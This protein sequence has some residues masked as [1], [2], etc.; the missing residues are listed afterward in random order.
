MAVIFNPDNVDSWLFKIYVKEK[1]MTMTKEELAKMLDRSQYPFKVTKAFKE[2]AKS[3]NLVIVYGAS[4]DLMEFRGAIDE[5]L[6]A[7]D[8]TTALLSP[9]S[10]LLLKSECNDDCPY[11]KA[12]ASNAIELRQV[13]CPES[14]NASWGYET[15]IPHATFDILEDDDLYC[16]G[17][18]FNLS[19]VKEASK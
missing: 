19:D 2:R 7:C 9:V 13:W 3:A 11:F 16:R 10:G 5:E 15:K 12:L 14:I 1:E 17:I 6:S 8:G 18:V 4:D